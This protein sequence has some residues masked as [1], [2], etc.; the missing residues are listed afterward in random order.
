MLHIRYIPAGSSTTILEHIVPR[1]IGTTKGGSRYIAEYGPEEYTMSLWVR[2]CKH[3]LVGDGDDP[4]DVR[5]AELHR[6]G[7]LKDGGNKVD[8]SQ[9]V[10]IFDGRE[11]LVIPNMPYP[12]ELTNDDG[13]EEARINKLR[14]PTPVDKKIHETIVSQ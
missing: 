9:R 7:E 5:F 6:G 2:L 12:W 10:A 13:S 3:R 8:Y 11:E 4:T 1:A 14:K